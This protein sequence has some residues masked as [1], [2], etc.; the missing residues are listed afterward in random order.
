M[1]KEDTGKELPMMTFESLR[2]TINEVSDWEGG[3]TYDR[4]RMLERITSHSGFSTEGATPREILDMVQK[5][6]AAV[7]NLPPGTG[8]DVADFA[9]KIL[10]DWTGRQKCPPT[11]AETG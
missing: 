7:Y 5:I 11:Y 10:A 9:R 3:L 1:A 8:G 4:F 2:D 6:L